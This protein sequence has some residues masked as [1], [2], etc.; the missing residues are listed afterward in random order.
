MSQANVEAFRGCFEAVNRG[1]ALGV[2]GFMDTEVQFE[3]QIAAVQGSYVGH[4]GI[5]DFLADLA[6]HFDDLQLDCPDVRDLGDRVLAL[7]FAR[8]IGKGSGIKLETP[9]TVLASFRRGRIAVYKD[10]G[11]RDQALEAA[12][13]TD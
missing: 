2:L 11:D 4:E 10:Y 6:E 13:L 1:D 5:R 3:C 9:V 7:G 8:A 12:G